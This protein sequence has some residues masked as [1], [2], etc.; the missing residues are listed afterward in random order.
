M[1]PIQVQVEDFSTG[2]FEDEETRALYESLPDVRAVVPAVL[3]GA[4]A[5]VPSAPEGAEAGP[6]AESFE[7]PPADGSAGGAEQPA[8]S[9]G[10]RAEAAEPEESGTGATTS[11]RAQ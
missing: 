5:D 8:S 9:L 2:P 11:V 7:E 10:D 4:T 3:L 1:V 6:A